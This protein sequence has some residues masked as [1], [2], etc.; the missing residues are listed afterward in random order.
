MRRHLRRSPATAISLVALFVALGGTGYA[1]FAV[2][3]NSVGS[4]QLQNGAVITS[5][6]AN[7]AVTPAKLLPGLTVSHATSADGLTAL[8]SGQSE[9]G[10]FAAGGG[11]STGGYFGFGITFARPLAQPISDQ[12]SGANH[13]IDTMANPDP[14]HCPGAGH[15]AP[16]YL[17]LYFH[18]HNGVGTVYGYDQESPYGTPS[19][20]AGIYAPITGNGSYVD[21]VWTVT[22]S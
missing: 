6:I 15:A 4:A 7:G 2:P 17:C 1:A 20:G 3:P 22:A 14:T 21:G 16:G 9:S 8:R 12:L 10:T 13:I 18:Y 5:K 19:V 11:S